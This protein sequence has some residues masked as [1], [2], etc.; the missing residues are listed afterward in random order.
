MSGRIGG[1]AS[2]IPSSFCTLKLMDVAVILLTGELSFRPESITVTDER[3][4]NNSGTDN[5]TSHQHSTGEI[6][7]NVGSNRCVTCA[8]L[9]TQSP[10]TPP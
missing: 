9:P 5:G 1:E 6:S 2:A 10:L 7:T 3:N 8:P 4:L